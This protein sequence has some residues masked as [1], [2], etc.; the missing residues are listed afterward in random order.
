[1]FTSTKWLVAIIIILIL[2]VADIAYYGTRTATPLAETGTIKIGIVAPLTGGGALVGQNA[3]NAIE[4][5]KADLKGAKNNYE[6]IVEDDQTDP[7]KSASAAQKLIDIDKVAALISVTS[8]TGN[9]VAPIAMKAGVL[10]IS[11]CSD[12][13]VADNKTSFIIYVTPEN[14]A[15]VWVAEAKKRGYKNVAMIT[16]AQAGIDAMANALKAEA[17]ANGMKV[18]FAERF[19]KSTNDFKTTLFKAEK[20]KPDIYYLVSFPPALDIVGKQYKELGLKNP[21]SGDVLDLSKDLKIFEGAWYANSK[22]SDQNFA[23]RLK[24][25]YP[26]TFFAVR[27]APYAYDTFNLLVKATENGKVSPATYVADLSDYSGVSGPLSKSSDGF[28]KSE[29]SIWVVKNGEPAQI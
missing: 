24:A 13:K 25:K 19:D 3:V 22:L 18:V 10:H 27:S 12:V 28:F 29:D 4:L 8:G 14:E 9:A 2:I 15:K 20:A 11:I 1:M 7:A 26:N 6:I 23:D 21:L 5:A 17:E 16:M